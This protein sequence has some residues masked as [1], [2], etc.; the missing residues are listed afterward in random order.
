MTIFRREKE[1]T[2]II[3]LYDNSK[4]V[5]DS[6]HRA[7]GVQNGIAANI[8]SKLKMRNPRAIAISIRVFFFF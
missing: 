2:R 4:K 1:R 8:R 6:Y 7:I 5:L 3:D